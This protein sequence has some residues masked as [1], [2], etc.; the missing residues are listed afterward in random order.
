[1]AEGARLESVYT[2]RY[3][4]FESLPHR[5]TPTKPTI[6]PSALSF[7]SPSYSG[8]YGQSSAPCIFIKIQYFI[9]ITLSKPFFIQ[10]WRLLPYRLVRSVRYENS[11]KTVAY[12]NSLEAVG[13]VK[14]P[15]KSNFETYNLNHRRKVSLVN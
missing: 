2:A 11:I 9:D 4:G 14:V 1:M 3:R 15:A 13:F 10:I 6:R 7:L 12:G 5:H 8:L